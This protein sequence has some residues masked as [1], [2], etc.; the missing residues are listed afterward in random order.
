MLFGV[1]DPVTEA[2]GWFLIVELGV[3]AAYAVW[4]MVREAPRR[5]LPPREREVR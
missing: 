2:Q 4:R 1:D 3:L 5:P